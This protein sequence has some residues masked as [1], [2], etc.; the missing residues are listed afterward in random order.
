MGVLSLDSYT[1]RKFPRSVRYYKPGQKVP[2]RFKA[3]VLDAN[4][5]VYGAAMK[6]FEYGDEDCVIRK[7]DDIPYDQKIIMVFEETWNQIC[8]IVEVIDCEEVFIAFDGCAPQ[9]KQAQQR[10]RRYPRPLPKEGSFDATH[11]STGTVFMHN[12]CSYV[13]FQIHASGWNKKVIFSSHNV[14]GE[15]EH[16]GLEYLRTF[17]N[18][19]V[20]MFGPDGDLIMLGLASPLDFYL[21]KVDHRTR[22]GF[23]KQYYTIRMNSIK[24]LIAK[25]TRGISMGDSVKSFVFLG[26]FLGNDF[27][28]RLEIFDLFISGIDD[29]YS[30]YQ[31]LNKSIIRQGRLDQSVFT[32]LLEL[33]AEEEPQLLSNRTKH[34]FPLLES[35]LDS[36]HLDFESFRSEYYEK[37][38]HVTTE[39]E[40]AVMCYNYLDTIWWTW[41]YYMK[42]CPTFHHYYKYHYPPFCSDL[43]KYSK[44]WR[45]PKFVASPPRTPF[46]QLVAIFASQSKRVVTCKVSQ[47]FYRRFVSES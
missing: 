27:V 16:K 13:K 26:S 3:L 17:K 21:F 35:H 2:G 40:V 43:A 29:M 7:N 39:K 20:V 9:A 6:V 37:W 33:L 14:P 24:P 28:A 31:K 8:D 36:G 25:W 10:Q 46:Q 34:P 4:P 5:F 47:V 19:K 44:K 15:G 45:I 30:R 18:E 22:A 41:V 42:G 11:I 23:D 32:E 1:R 12:L 38:A